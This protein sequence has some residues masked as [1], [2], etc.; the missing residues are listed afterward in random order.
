MIVIMISSKQLLKPS[1]CLTWDHRDIER[2]R[3]REREGGGG[4]LLRRFKERSI[5]TRPVPGY[6]WA[7][8]KQKA[9]LHFTEVSES[10]TM[11]ALPDM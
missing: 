2:E 3:E 5:E 7:V 9:R 6:T 8:E 10:L 1:T 4:R 11:L